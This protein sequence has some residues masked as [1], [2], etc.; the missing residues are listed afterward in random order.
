MIIVIPNS[1]GVREP[2]L[3]D[4][5]IS[6]I[7]KNVPPYFFEIVGCLGDDHGGKA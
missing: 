6:M 2:V 7:C 4:H 3:L 5:Y 1:L